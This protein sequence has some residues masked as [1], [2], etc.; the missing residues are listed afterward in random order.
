RTDTNVA[1]HRILPMYSTPELFQKNEKNYYRL[2]TG[3]DDVVGNMMSRLKDIG[4]DSNTIII[5][6]ENN[7]FMMGDHN[8]QGKWY[9]YNASIRV[10]MIIYDASL[11]DKLKQIRPKEIALNID[12]APTILSLAGVPV[13]DSMQGVNLIALLQHK[14]PDRKAFFYQHYFWGSPRIPKVERVV[15]KR[16]KYIKYIENGYEEFFDE[17]YDPHEI[18]N[19][20]RDPKYQLRLEKMRRM[21]KKWKKI[22]K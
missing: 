4:I 15:N 20:S 11:P 16:F 8:M 18:D 22:V 1:R 10:P 14:I 12:I 6:M 17:K 13:P 9:G 5:F 7:G 19:L 2:I 21:Y 3:V